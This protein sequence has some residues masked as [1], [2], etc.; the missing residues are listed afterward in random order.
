M[1]RGVAVLSV[2]ALLGLV[3]AGAACAA[4]SGSGREG[5][6]APDDRARAERLDMVESQIAA[7]GIRDPAVLEAM[8][9]VPRHRFVP[10]GESRFAHADGPLPIGHEQTISQP[11]IV[12]LM[13]ELLRPTRSMKVLEVGTGSG[14]QAA[15]LAECVGEVYTIEIVE[16]LGERARK[17]L[18]ELGYDNVRVRIGDGYD[19]WPEAAPFDAI[20][21]TAAPE[22]IPQPLLDQLKIGGRLVLPVGVG[23]QDLV[24]VTRTDRGV[25]REVVTGV[26]FVPMTG[27]VRGEKP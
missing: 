8:R 1:A 10:A 6:T 5:P 25:E 14:Y 27:K 2:A 7:R 18:A 17:L 16:P 23:I 9:K 21:V 20:M 4:G 3:G 24:V 15:V 12:A 19:G 13:T 22:R 11:Y 26:R